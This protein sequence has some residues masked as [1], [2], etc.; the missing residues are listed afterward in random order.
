MLQFLFSDWFP[1]FPKIKIISFKLL[2][3]MLD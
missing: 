3:Y 2:M 1:M